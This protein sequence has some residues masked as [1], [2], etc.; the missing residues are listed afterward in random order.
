MKVIEAK[1]IA[2]AWLGGAPYLRG[3]P[4]WADLTVLL[5]V[6][7]PALVRKHDR[8]VANI[9]D[10]FLRDHGSFSNHTVAEQF[11]LVMSIA[12]G[13]CRVFMK[14]IQTR[15]IQ[16]SKST[17]RIAGAPTHIAY[18]VGSQPEERCTTPSKTASKKCA[19]KPASH[20]FMS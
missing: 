3:L 7:D 5:H 12:T 16:S 10:S 18:C 13:V 2:E 19:I 20:P 17:L 6:S 15:Y 9:L 4:D 14:I 1:T 11:P 8:E